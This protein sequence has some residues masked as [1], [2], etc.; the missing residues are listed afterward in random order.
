MIKLNKKCVNFIY[1][2]KIKEKIVVKHSIIFI[3][4][5]SGFL[6]KSSYVCTLKKAHNNIFFFSLQFLDKIYF[7]LFLLKKTP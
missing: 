2:Y 1:Y 3:V 7:F 6:F 5:R 4:M